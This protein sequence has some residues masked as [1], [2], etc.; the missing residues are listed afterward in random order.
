MFGQERGN[1]LVHDRN[2]NRLGE[3][4]ELRREREGERRRAEKRKGV[5]V[6]EDAEDGLGAPIKVQKVSGVRPQR[7][8]PSG[9]QTVLVSQGCGKGGGR[10]GGGFERHLQPPPFPLEKM[11]H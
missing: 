7:D 3:Y 6:F 11:S 2:L 8:K 4:R 10:R 5:A 9:P 1:L